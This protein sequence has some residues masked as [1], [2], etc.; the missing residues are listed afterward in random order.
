M[1]FVPFVHFINLYTSKEYFKALG[2]EL[3]KA[4]EKGLNFLI[5]FIIVACTYSRAICTKYS[6]CNMCKK[7]GKI[8]PT[9]FSEFLTVVLMRE[10]YTGIDNVRAMMI[11]LIAE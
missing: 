9:R 8:Y 10:F 2:L 5:R 11:R 4:K 1:S 7:K 3:L 6:V